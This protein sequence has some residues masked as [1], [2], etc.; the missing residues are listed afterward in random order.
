MAIVIVTIDYVTTLHPMYDSGE[1]HCSF[2]L[3]CAGGFGFSCSRL[4]Y[5]ELQP[6]IA[7]T[8]YPFAD[9]N[10]YDPLGSTIDVKNVQIKIT[11]Y[12]I[13]FRFAETVVVLG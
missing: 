11:E 6:A 13:Q 9:K 3:T 12:A 2:N 4:G 5:V 7:M 1:F 8:S 10:R